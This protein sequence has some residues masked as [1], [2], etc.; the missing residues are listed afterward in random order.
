VRAVFGRSEQDLAERLSGEREVVDELKDGADGLGQGVL[1]VGEAAAYVGVAGFEDAQLV[2][3][4]ELYGA[5]VA[6]VDPA[7][8]SLFVNQLAHD[9]S[10]VVGKIWA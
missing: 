10:F 7:G 5:E 2:N 3:G 9:L 8:L 4:G 6:S 1:E